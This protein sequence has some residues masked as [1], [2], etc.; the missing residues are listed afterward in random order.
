MQAWITTDGAAGPA[1]VE[2]V[3]IMPPTNSRPLVTSDNESKVRVSD[4]ELP[5][6]QSIMSKVWQVEHV[7]DKGAWVAMPAKC[8]GWEIYI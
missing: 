1:T 8:H 2:P 4:K 3:R 7:L 5:T 6:L